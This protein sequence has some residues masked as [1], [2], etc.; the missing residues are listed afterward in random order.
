MALVDNVVSLG[1]AY[2]VVLPLCF[3]LLGRAPRRPRAALCGILSVLLLMLVGYFFVY[4][5]TPL[6]LAGHLRTSLDRLLLHLWPAAILA[7]FL[8][9]ADPMELLA[10]AAEGGEMGTVNWTVVGLGRA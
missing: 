4:V 3:L 1:K 9:L 7:I 10:A 6:E 5:T 8:A 2:V